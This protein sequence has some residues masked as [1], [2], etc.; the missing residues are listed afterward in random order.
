MKQVIEK[1]VKLD[2]EFQRLRDVEAENYFDLIDQARERWGPNYSSVSREEFEAFL[3]SRWIHRPTR[4]LRE[5]NENLAE[6]VAKA[7]GDL[8]NVVAILRDYDG[9]DSSNAEKLKGLIDDVVG[10][11][12]KGCPYVSVTKWRKK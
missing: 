1:L 2:E 10:W 5:Q 12:D 6:D 7:K 3:D 8:A 11:V 9:Y 4:G